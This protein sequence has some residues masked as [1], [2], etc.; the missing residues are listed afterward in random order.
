M[1]DYVHAAF[2]AYRIAELPESP[3]PKPIESIMPSFDEAPIHPLLEH[4]NNFSTSLS[5][6][7]KINFGGTEEDYQKKHKKV[8]D[9]YSSNKFYANNFKKNR[10]RK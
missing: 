1:N 9:R 3:D 8:K 7:S 4:F 10:R 2:W 6:L 5:E